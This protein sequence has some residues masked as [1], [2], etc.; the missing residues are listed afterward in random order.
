[1]QAVTLL[2]EITH[3]IFMSCCLP[4]REAV[5][6]RTPTPDV[7]YKVKCLAY[8]ADRQDQQIQLFLR[9]CRQNPKM[10]PSPQLLRELLVRAN[11]AKAMRK[12]LETIE[13]GKAQ[14]EYVQQLRSLNGFI[15]SYNQVGENTLKRLEQ[16]VG[17]FLEEQD[18]QEQLVGDATET[19]QEFSRPSPLAVE[20]NPDE[21]M[22]TLEE[23]Y[24]DDDADDPGEAAHLY[25]QFPSVPQ[26]PLRPTRHVAQEAP[27]PPRRKMPV[28]SPMM[29]Y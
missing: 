1:M 24:P 19:I 4:L 7:E 22:K 17:V 14:M 29:S 2:S 20:L 10:K 27:P 5:R 28:A 18:E 26:T 8:M 11:S 9:E 21:L 16:E 13:G 15:K 25:E 3:R 12:L 23:L 6:T